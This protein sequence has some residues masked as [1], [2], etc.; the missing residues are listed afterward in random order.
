MG[1]YPAPPLGDG[2]MQGGVGWTR[3]GDKIILYANGEVFRNP[4]GI[5]FAHDGGKMEITK[6][7]IVNGIVT[8]L[9]YTT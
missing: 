1:K 8:E 6:L 2:K 5:D 7:T 9:E 4:E 3:E